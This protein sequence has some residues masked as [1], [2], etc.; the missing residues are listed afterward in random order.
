MTETN[1]PPVALLSYGFRPFFLLAALWSAAAIAVWLWLLHTGSQLP[2]RFDAMTWHIHEMIFGFVMAAIAGFLLT[3]IANWTGRPPIQGLTLGVLVTAWIVGRFVCWYSAALPPALVLVGDLA[4]PI[5]L[6]IL[7]LR[8]VM[9]ARNWRNMPMAAP[10]AVLG[11]ADLLMHLASLGWNLPSEIGWHLSIAAILVLLSAVA[12]RIVPAFTRNWLKKT[13]SGNLPA[14]GMLDRVS[15]GLLHASI[16]AWA[17][18][19]ES[20]WAGIGLLGAAVANGWRLLRWRGLA[21]RGE[22]LLLI[23]HI[24]YCWLVVGIALLG[25]SILWPAVPL[26]AAIHALTAGAIGTM[27]LAVMTRA[28]RGHTGRALIADRSTGLIYALVLAAGCA[29]VAAGFVAGSAAVL[30]LSGVLWIAA[31]GLFF[32]VYAPVLTQPRPSET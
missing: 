16:L 2:S 24:G 31:Y 7:V 8:E 22:F 29:R 28:T 14:A 11:V 9:L 21:V 3:A 6:V 19:P 20:R 32:V 12:G 26:T 18:F 25:A 23:L 5:L 4:L 27:V 15:S 17:F 1:K 30:N 13:G 10:V